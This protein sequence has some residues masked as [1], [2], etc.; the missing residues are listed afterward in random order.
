MREKDG[1]TFGFVRFTDL[2]DQREALIHMNGFNGLGEKPI[3]VSM[4][5]P[6]HTLASNI[7]DNSAQYSHMY[8][9]YWS[10]RGAW[11]NY[12]SYQV[13]CFLRLPVTDN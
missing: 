10:D 1:K 9:S 3:K 12:G 6:K 7:G 2:N 4:A 13:S 5:I 8:E 11:A